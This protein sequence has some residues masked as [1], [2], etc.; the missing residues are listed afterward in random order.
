MLFNVNNKG[1]EKKLI[2]GLKGERRNKK[3]MI[4][5][6]NTKLHR[7]HYRFIANLTSITREHIASFLFY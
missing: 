5:K 1:R 2:A 4:V 6:F 3:I 7:H